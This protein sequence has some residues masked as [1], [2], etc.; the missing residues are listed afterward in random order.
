MRFRFRNAVTP[1]L[2]AALTLPALAACGS[3]S[4]PSGAA[5]S[6]IATFAEQPGT[7]LNYIFPLIPGNFDLTNISQFEDLMWRPLYWIGTSSGA[8]QY[9]TSLSLAALPQFSDN[10]SVVTITLKNYK[11]SDG[12]PVTARDV[13]FWI[14]LV[15]AAV[16]EDPLN[17]G[18]YVHG[19][20]PDNIK[21]V[22]VL[23]SNSLRLVLN[24]SYNPTWFTYNQLSQLTPIPQQAWDKT[25]A[26]G[27]IGNYDLT[28]QGAE[29]VYNFLA[30]QSKILS[31]YA[32]NPLWQVVDGPWRIK[33]FTTTSQVTFVP[34][35]K[36]SGPV[37]PQL[38]E[39]IEEPFTSESAEYNALRSGSLTYGYLPESDIPSKGAIA[40]EGYSLLPWKLWAINYLAINYN[41][42]T[43]GSIFR[44]LY[45]RQAFESLVNQ[46]QYVSDAL[47]GY[48]TPTYGPV[49]VDLANPYVASVERA[50]PYPYDPAKAKM[51]LQAHGW[52]VTPGGQSV[53]VHQGTAADECGAGIVA[54]ARLTFNLLYASGLTTLAQ[55]VQGL[56]SNL[57]Q[58]GITL[59]LQS[60]PASS[61]LGS[62]DVC[63]PSQSDCK[64]QMLNWGSGY[65]LIPNYD[66]TGEQFFETGASSN[67]GSYSDPAM[68]Q[69]ISATNLTES[70][71]AMS[72]YETYAADQLPV[73]WFPETDYQLSEVAGDLSGVTPQNPEEDITP[74]DWY[75]SGAK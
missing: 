1:I 49:P 46:S 3:S 75:F 39:F 25:S 43:V 27:P 67:F 7:I 37:K 57:S 21:T 72:R 61:V 59:E 34:N 48:G 17:W 2:A 62:A 16:K 45:V 26:N 10:D 12:A 64:W 42:P 19:Y 8:P 73:L 22:Q 52:R 63:T 33:A 15:K 24:R 29:Q 6:N 55:E 47:H 58:A 69:Y 71:G 30:A 31:T 65:I 51:L 40:A 14:N 66:P 28:A 38:K 50:N 60:T 13:Q 35:A 23:S 5:K 20:F 32:T 41:N 11:W 4:S 68:N 44:Q 18:G 36:Y 70:A 56:K 53:C 54:G 9:N 74:E